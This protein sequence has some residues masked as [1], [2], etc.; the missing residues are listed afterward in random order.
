MAGLLM[1]TKTRKNKNDDDNDNDNNR[2]DKMC[3][4]DDVDA[5]KPSFCP[6]LREATRQAVSVSADN[7][8]RLICI[9]PAS[10]SLI[11][12]MTVFVMILMIMII[13]IR[14][15]MITIII[16]IMITTTANLKSADNNE[17]LICS[18]LCSLVMQGVVMR[19]LGLV[20]Q[21]SGL[22]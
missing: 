9:Q 5:L 10:P 16:I 8:E 3:V 1:L 7:N 19:I 2:S 14:K 6:H 15:I 18:Q 20:N 4:D 13:T 12:M 11:M 17:R 21:Q 22:F